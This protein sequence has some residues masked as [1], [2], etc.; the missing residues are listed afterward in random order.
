MGKL[1]AHSVLI[2]SGTTTLNVTVDDGAVVRGITRLS[3]VG[4]HSDSCAFKMANTC[5]W[6]GRGTLKEMAS[7]GMTAG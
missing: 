4:H 6:S 7:T 3:N 1:I 5:P 2:I